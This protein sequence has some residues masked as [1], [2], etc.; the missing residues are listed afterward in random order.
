MR[1][2]SV[3]HTSAEFVAFYNALREFIREEVDSVEIDATGEYPESVVD[4]LRKLGAF[5]MKIPKKYGGLGF[6]QS[7]YCRALEIV[8]ERWS[9]L[10]LRNAIFGGITRFSDFQRSL[11]ISPNVL[12]KRLENFV[13]EGIMTN[14]MGPDSSGHLEYRLTDKGRAWLA[15]RRSRCSR[16]FLPLR[17]RPLRAGRE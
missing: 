10:I 3:R 16:P 1:P 5:G 15:G 11:A 9:L 14:S 12:A 2:R 8:G 17:P 7:E 13:Q 6:S 4:G